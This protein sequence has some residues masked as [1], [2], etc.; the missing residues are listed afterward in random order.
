MQ[1]GKQALDG[2]I[3]A[4][5]QRLRFKQLVIRRAAQLLVLSL[6]VK[7]LELPFENV[8]IHKA[9]HIRIGDVSAVGFEHCDGAGHKANELIIASLDAAAP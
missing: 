2:V 7:K 5:A 3:D 8:V 6:R 1:R 4:E 9:Q